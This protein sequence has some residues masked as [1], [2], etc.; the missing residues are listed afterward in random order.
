MPTNTDGEE[1][2]RFYIAGPMQG[3]DNHNY[4][5]FQAAADYIRSMGTEVFSPHEA[6]E[7]DQTRPLADYYLWNLP[8]LLESTD[9]AFLPGWQNSSGAR[10]EYLIAKD[11]GLNL[12]QVVFMQQGD[13]D[14]YVFGVFNHLEAPVELEAGAVVRNGER[15]ASYGPPLQDFTRTANM[16]ASLGIGTSQDPADVALAMTALKMSR[17]KGT[18]GH[19]D[20]IVDALGYLICY[21][22]IVREN[23]GHV[24]L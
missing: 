19:Y 8:S 21:S 2:R 6:Y 7:G 20:S 13:S 5:R 18:R 11:L 22:R 24:Q 1:L 12:H 14:E 23:D 9:V 4:L 3:V 17:L 16:W 10:I 15:E